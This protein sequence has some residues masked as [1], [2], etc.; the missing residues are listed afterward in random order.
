LETHDAYLALVAPSL[1]TA[2][3]KARRARTGS[4]D[5][6][7]PREKRIVYSGRKLPPF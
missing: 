5:L 1:F 4:L 7:T 2:A 3:S 6:S